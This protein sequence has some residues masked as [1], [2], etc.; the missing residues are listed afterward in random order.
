[1]L[2]Q[3]Y[4]ELEKDILKK[5]NI[6]YLITF[7]NN[8]K[9]I[10][11]TTRKLSIRLRGYLT[12]S[13]RNKH[14]LKMLNAILFYDKCKVEILCECLSLIELNKKEPEFIKTYNSVETGYNSN[15]GG[16]NTLTTEDT[17]KKI[18]LKNSGKKRSQEVKDKMGLAHRGKKLEDWHKTQ[19]GIKNSKKVINI[20]TGDRFNSVKETAEFYDCNP[21]DLAIYISGKYMYKGNRLC[22]EDNIHNEFAK[23]QKRKIKNVNTGDV[24][25][26][27]KEAAISIGAIHSNL[28][29]AVSNNRKCRGY[30]WQYID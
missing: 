8:K 1:M 27:I 6:I 19:I 3:N 13:K 22:Y 29:F 4:F 28:R 25:N 15:Y 21:K 10:G 12:D 17:K 16:D 26:S 5:S 30:K 20:D 24:Y 14:N 11:Q 9:Y 2:Y 7:E 18:S 23:P